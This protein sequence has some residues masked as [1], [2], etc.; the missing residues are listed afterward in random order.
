LGG[1]L[2][3]ADDKV[4]PGEKMAD[5]PDKLVTGGLTW[6]YKGFRLDAAGRYIGRQ[7]IIDND[8]GAP[9]NITIKSYFIMDLGLAKTIMLSGSGVQWAKSVKFSI[10]VSNLF[11]KYYYNEAYVQS[12]TPYAGPTEFAAPGAP[13][14]VIGQIEV[15]F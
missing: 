1:G 11:D 2:S 14:S 4:T 13:R 7:Y 6:E 9:S 5:V 12:N 8:N 15:A 3:V 10:R